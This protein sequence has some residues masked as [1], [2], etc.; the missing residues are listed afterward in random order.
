MLDRHILQH[1]VGQ[2]LG[3]TEF[4]EVTVEADAALDLSKFDVSRHAGVLLD[5]V[6]DVKMV[7]A[8]REVL[9]G[10]AKVD[11]GGTS[12]TMMYAYPF[13]LCRRAVVVTLD[14]AAANLAFFRTH[15]WLSSPENVIVLTLGGPAWARA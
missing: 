2:Q 1:H 3:L 11:M 14:L 10:R 12:G 13:S 6:A 15:H 8:H 7:A 9:Q 4:L 5:G